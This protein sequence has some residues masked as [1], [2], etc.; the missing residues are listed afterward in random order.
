M[1]LINLIERISVPIACHVLPKR[2]RKTMQ[3]ALFLNTL[4]AHLQETKGQFSCPIPSK[5][6]ILMCVSVC[7]VNIDKSHAYITHKLP[8][9]IITLL[10]KGCS[11]NN[12]AYTPPLSKN[13]HYMRDFRSL[14][15]KLRAE[16]ASSSIIYNVKYRVQHLSYD[17]FPCL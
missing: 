9:W 10:H 4:H 14:F 12:I 17:R 2:K 7:I 1:I 13:G 8:F 16:R 5:L 3:M 11:F 6:S 15:V